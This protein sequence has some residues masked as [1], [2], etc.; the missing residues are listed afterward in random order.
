MGAEASVLPWVTGFIGLHRSLGIRN[1][2]NIPGNQFEM[3]GNAHVAAASSQWPDSE[4][5]FLEA[6]KTFW[7]EEEMLSTGTWRSPLGWA[8][9]MLLS[10]VEACNAQAWCQK[11]V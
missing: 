1:S 2:Q 9:E 4:K 10:S 6:S 7:K 8:G 11:D 3:V 5:Q